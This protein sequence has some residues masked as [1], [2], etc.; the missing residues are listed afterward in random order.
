M[1]NK[2]NGKSRITF[3]N[4][5]GNDVSGAGAAK[6]AAMTNG[7]LWQNGLQRA[8]TGQTTLEE[9]IRVVAVDMI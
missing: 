9:I 5:L 3:R 2:P 6:D 1:G 8:V 7:T 4:D